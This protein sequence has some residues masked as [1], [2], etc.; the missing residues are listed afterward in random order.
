MTKLRDF[1]MGHLNTEPRLF[2]PSL[3]EGSSRQTPDVNEMDVR[4]AME[5]SYCAAAAETTASNDDDDGDLDPFPDDGYPPGTRY[6]RFSWSDDP[7]HHLSDTLRAKVNNAAAAPPT[8]PITPID[9]PSASSASTPAPGAAALLPLYSISQPPSRPLTPF[10]PTT[11]SLSDF[12]SSFSKSLLTSQFPTEPSQYPLFT[13]LVMISTY[14]LSL[15]D[16][17]LSRERAWQRMS[18]TGGSGRLDYGVQMMAR[19]MMPTPRNLPGMEVKGP[20]IWDVVKAAEVRGFMV[21]WDLF[22]ISPRVGAGAGA[23]AAVTGPAPAPTLQMKARLRRDAP[24]VANE[25]DRPSL[26]ADRL[27]LKYFKQV[28]FTHARRPIKLF[29]RL[30]PAHLDPSTT[31]TSSL[32]PSPPRGTDLPPAPLEIHD[33]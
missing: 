8:T 26:T 10:D 20:G 6:I 5:E 33:I 27:I 2:S 11:L 12:A 28:G 3:N 15:L 22:L 1:G 17:V 29:A 23:G 24:A 19:P 14:L 16:P 9:P 31:L 32:S 13:Q 30:P 21:H 7:F 4:K 18:E 25:R